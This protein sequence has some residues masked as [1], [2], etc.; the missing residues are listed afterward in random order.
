M[1][2]RVEPGELGLDL[3]VGILDGLL[4]LGALALPGDDLAG[5]ELVEQSVLTAASFIT[6]LLP[7]RRNQLGQLPPFA[8]RRI[9]QTI[10]AADQ[11]RPHAVR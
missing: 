9:G 7:Q 4:S 1:R 3:L 5:R 6:R 11:R 8:A 10:D 2:R